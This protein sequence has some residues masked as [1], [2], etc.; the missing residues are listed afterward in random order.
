MKMIAN[1][2]MF[3]HLIFLGFCSVWG[4]RFLLRF[5]VI[6]PKTISRGKIHGCLKK[7]YVAPALTNMMIQVTVF[8]I[9]A[10]NDATA[11]KTKKPT[12]IGATNLKM[13]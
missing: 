9:E 13:S 10:P 3:H 12:A 7:T 6:P 11:A 5:V 8:L 4:I 2:Q 1:S